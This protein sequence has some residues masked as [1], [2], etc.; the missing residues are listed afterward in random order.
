MQC[1][2]LPAAHSRNEPQPLHTHLVPQL[3]LMVDS[4]VAAGSNQVAGAGQGLR[5]LL[6]LPVFLALSCGQ[7]QQRQA[8][9]LQVNSRS[10][11]ANGMVCTHCVGLHRESGVNPHFRRNKPTHTH[12]YTKYQKH[13]LLALTCNVN[14]QSSGAPDSCNWVKHRG[15][16]EGSSG[17]SVAQ[18][19]AAAVP[20]AASRRCCRC[21]VPKAFGACCC[22]AGEQQ[23]PGS[24]L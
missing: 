1:G 23:L 10:A 9:M 15:T 20:A 21:I 12:I 19:P 2:S 8:T 16:L 3:L 18:P 22:T 6:E 7:Q 14:Q 24:C 4:R 17:S 11:W 5:L 13:Q